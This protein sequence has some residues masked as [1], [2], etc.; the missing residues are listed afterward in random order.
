MYIRKVTQKNSETGKIY[1]THRLVETYRNSENKVRQRVLLNLG[2][3][4]TI[5]QDEW[6]LLADRI[7]EI[8]SG[9]RI[10]FEYDPQIEK[11]AQKIA[12][13]VVHRASN[14][15]EPK[16]EKINDYQEIDINT[17]ES[18]NIRNIGPEYLGLEVAKELN[19]DKLLCELRFNNKQINTA[20]G[21]IIGKLVMPGSERSIHKYLQSRSG[22]DELLGCDFQQLSLNQLYQISDK[23]VINKDIIEEKVFKREKEIFGLE[24]IITLY[25]LTNTYFEGKCISNTKAAFGRSKEKRRDCRLVTLAM[26]L[27]SSGFP[28]RSEV[29]EGNASEPKTLQK[30]MNKLC[31]NDKKPTVV[32]DAGISSEENLK[33]L[34]ENEYNYIVVSKKAKKILPDK[35]DFIID[36][37]KKYLIKAK[38]IDNKVN[39]EKELYCYSE[40][41]EEKEKSMFNQASGRY[42]QSLA[43]LSENLTKKRTKKDYQYILQKIGRLKEKYKRIAKAY[44]VTINADDKKEKATEIKWRKLPYKQKKPG[45]YCLRTN[46]EDLDEQTFWDIYIML[47]DLEAA[48]RCLKTELGLRPVYHH[49]TKRVDG[50]IFITVLA[51]HLMH[52]IRSKLKVAGIHENWITIR[53]ELYNHCRITTS[54]KLKNGKTLHV[55]KSSRPTPR[56]IEIYKALKLNIIPGKTEK[57]IL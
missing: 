57:I 30:M 11:E 23:L 13:L 10:L 49:K 12:K 8:I 29:F 43:K 53:K 18:Q 37:E 7:E 32:L 2:K 55:R 21:S 15:T 56:Q 46:R 41:K 52:M 17:I 51:Y 20:L 54:M 40:A 27:D 38:L 24:D 45:V 39:G 6:K 33:W 19:I 14:L 5:A 4:F 36:H 31:K 3:N 47:T 48:F 28:K 16:E 44:E 50:H 34:K 22:L 9:Q 42:E 26:V 1:F 25:D 35:T